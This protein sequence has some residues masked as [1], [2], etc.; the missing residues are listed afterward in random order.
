[1]PP[2][3]LPIR[4]ALLAALLSS[5]DGPQRIEV[6]ESRRP[7]EGEP[8][9]KVGLT[10]QQRYAENE[11]QQMLTWRIPE[12]WIPLSATQFRHINFAFG[13]SREGECYLTLLSVSRNGGV[14]ENLN[15][16]LA[17][18]GKPPITREQMDA[19]PRRTLLGKEVPFLDVTGTYS[20]A[21]GPMMEAA[22]PREGWRMLGVILEA[23][24]FLFT[25]K[26]TGPEA[27]VR[28]E[29]ARF[30]EFCRSIAPAPNLHASP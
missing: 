9:P 28:E 17:Q 25:V 13:P 15:R 19:L 29:V 8:P 18:M 1:M 16:W 11:A 5:C 23:P 4:A 14:L 24:G 10:A 30:D 2:P 7:F 22:V 21:S 6:K 12:G 27:I 3:G 20:G 26:L